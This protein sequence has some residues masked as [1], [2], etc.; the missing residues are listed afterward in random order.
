MG[1]SQEQEK[2][3]S[4]K[5]SAEHVKQ[6]EQSGRK[7]S[8]IEGWHAINE[9]NRI[10]GFGD[11]CRETVYLKE[12]CRLEFE[13]NGRT[14]YKVGY[15]AKVRVTVYFHDGMSPSISREGTGYGQ[16]TMGDLYDAMESAGKEA[17]T[18]AMKRALMTFGNP[19]G[20]ALYDKDQ[21]NVAPETDPNEVKSVDFARGYKVI[22]ESA[23]DKA[24]LDKENK[25]KI[26]YAARYPEA[27]KLLVEAG[28]PL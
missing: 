6:R 12:V 1:F 9:A 13:K 18:D 26:D 24:A 5:L 19:F 23:P 27:R 22:R 17:E 15:E 8:Y 10:F 25:A 11:W 2:M 21:T 14:M 7:L 3:L 28:V 16:G 20:L 4:A